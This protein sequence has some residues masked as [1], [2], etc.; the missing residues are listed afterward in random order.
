MG[1]KSLSS[2]HR[3]DSAMIW[4]SYIYDKKLKWLS[5]NLWFAYI[6]FYKVIF[7]FSFEKSKFKRNVYCNFSK[8][9]LSTKLVNYKHPSK[10]KTR[11]CY[12]IDLYCVEA[13]NYLLLLNLY[14]FTTLTFYK[15]KQNKKISMKKLNNFF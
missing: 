5:Y 7:F 13:F 8:N 4:S 12:Y 10:T 3:V 6:Q 1:Q 2:L 11:F 15:K 9:F 14:F